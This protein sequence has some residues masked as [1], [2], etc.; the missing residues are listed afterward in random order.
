MKKSIYRSLFLVNLAVAANASLLPNP[1]PDFRLVVTGG[2]NGYHTGQEQFYDSPLFR[3]GS[4]CPFT[5]TDA[6]YETYAS[7]DTL[8]FSSDPIDLKK[9]IEP[10]SHV[11]SPFFLGL[12][13]SQFFGIKRAAG[14]FIDFDTGTLNRELGGVVKKTHYQVRKVG[15]ALVYAIDFSLNQKGVY[16]PR[17]LGEI[18]KIWGALGKNSSGEEYYFFP[19]DFRSTQ[20]TF[21]L[22]DNLLERDGPNARYVDLGNAL[23]RSDFENIDMANEM[24]ELLQARDPAVLAM[25]RYDLSALSEI[26]TNNAYIAALRGKGAPPVSRRVAIGKT[27][28]RFLALGDIS[29]FASGFL[30]PELK[31]LTTRSSIEGIKFNQEDLVI[32]LSENRL[33]TFKAIEY[34]ILD[35][36]LSLSWLRG[37]SLPARDDIV[38]E[39]NEREGVRSVAPLVRISSSDVTEISVWKSAPGHIKRVLIE[40]HAIVGGLSHTEPTTNTL[41]LPRKKWTDQDYDSMLSNILLNVYPNSEIVI[42][43]KRISKT[44]IDA[45]LTARLAESLIAPTGRAIEIKLGGTYVNQVLK[46]IK[47]NRFDLDV[48][49]TNTLQ[50]GVNE[51]ETYKLVVTEKVLAALS[52]FIARESIFAGSSNPALSVQTAL[53]E[54]N[55]D[56]MKFLTELRKREDRSSASLDDRYNLLQSSPTMVQLVRAAIYENKTL[57]ARPHRNVLVFDVSDLDFGFKFN[58]TNSNLAAWQKDAKT[59]TKLAFDESRFWDKNYRNFL[60]YTKIGLYYVMPKLE[61]G[62]IGSVKYYH[63]DQQKDNAIAQTADEI[64]AIRPQKDSVKMELEA[65]LPTKVFISPLGRLTY[66]TQIWPNALLTDLEPKYWPKRVHDVRLF[67]GVTPKPRLG[68]ELFRV[69]ALIGYDFSQDSTKQSL[70]FGFE[71]GGAYKYDWRYFSFRVDSNL[72]KLFPIVNNPAPLRMGVV[73]LTDAKIEIPIVAG[74][75]ASALTGI[76]I[77]ERMDTPWSY[78]VGAMFGMALS[79]GNR[80]KWLL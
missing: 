68:Y 43:E 12:D 46:A 62:L 80:M 75:S 11:S 26:P 42:M 19:R 8:Y 52:D 24:H 73:W 37:G 66:E 20:K 77:G 67:L 33:S 40:R 39:G 58:A 31:P 32:A 1:P 13:A 54:S 51:S 18:R 9:L 76:T 47:K 65:L 6:A 78:G 74:F 71:L 10:A 23:T 56:A 15:A 35:M 16:W 61:L 44:P 36:V 17:D 25:G 27:E 2:L 48:V 49:V 60:L 3:L 69:G 29:D 72:R 45:A 70:G 38:L 55:K 53:S 5:I 7:G 30:D 4:N 21:E 22:V 28:V 79:Y 50:R 64:G 14:H 63:P 34:P 41:V 57:E 59:N